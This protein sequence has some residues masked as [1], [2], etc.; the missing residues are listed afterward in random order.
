M[1]EDGTLPI[2]YDHPCHILSTCLLRFVAAELA[3]L[4]YARVFFLGKNLLKSDI[5]NRPA[6]CTKEKNVQKS[7]ILPDYEIQ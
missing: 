6:T 1:D 7:K 3:S 2:R 5:K 4:R